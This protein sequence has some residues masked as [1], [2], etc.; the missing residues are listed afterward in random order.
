MNPTSIMKLLSAK[1]QFEANHPKFAAFIGTMF[2]RPLEEGT[3]LEVTLTRPGE[4]PVTAN[5][6]LQQSDLELLA[7]LK[8][9]GT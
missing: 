3:I 2:T 8:K 7:E 9:L 5:M 4:K 6:K 1:N